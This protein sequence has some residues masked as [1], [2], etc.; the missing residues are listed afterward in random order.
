MQAPPEK[1]TALDP[2]RNWPVIPCP[3]VHRRN[4]RVYHRGAMDFSRAALSATIALPIF[5]C[6]AISIWCAYKVISEDSE[7]QSD[8][9]GWLC[10]AS[11][12]ASLFPQK[13]LPALLNLSAQVFSLRIDLYLEVTERLCGNPSFALGRFF[14]GHPK[15]ALISAISYNSM[16]LGIIVAALAYV[17]RPE[18]G[19]VV[20]VMLVNLFAAVPIYFLL[21]ASGPRNVFV[22]YPFYAAMGSPHLISVHAE[23]NCIP[24]VHFATTLLLVY[25]F[26]RS[27]PAR[28]LA[29]AHSALTAM[30]CLGFGEHYLID[31]VVAVPYALAVLWIC[32][33]QGR[34]LTRLRAL[35]ES[36]LTASGQAR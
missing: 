17:K 27:K 29:V 35:R 21:P 2:A 3:G 34:V 1:H 5:V 36:T 19:R 33:E 16:P 10:V 6:L 31:L 28:I 26:W 7:A 23:P 25:F 9:Y 13:L 24:S 8:R 22:D 4:P 30:A 12:A 18:F 15:L 32:R 14:M 11:V 20:A